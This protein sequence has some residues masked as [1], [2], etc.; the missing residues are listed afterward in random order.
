MRIKNGERVEDDYCLQVVGSL[1]SDGQFDVLTSIQ[2][3]FT[4]LTLLAITPRAELQCC[5]HQ[6]GTTR[7]PQAFADLATLAFG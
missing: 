5:L 6:V 4:I 7:C 3:W 2:R 1:T